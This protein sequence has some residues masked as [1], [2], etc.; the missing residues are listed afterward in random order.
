MGGLGEGFWDFLDHIDDV[1][2]DKE[3]IEKG[4]HVKLK[5]KYKY[6]PHK[7]ENEDKEEDEIM[8]HPDEYED[9]GEEEISNLD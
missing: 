8:E 7:F 1:V 9:E 6:N 4:E 3:L 2:G 5:E